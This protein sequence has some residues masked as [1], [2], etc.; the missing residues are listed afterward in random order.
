MPKIS[1]GI[2]KR[3]YLVEDLLLL[4]GI[5][6][7]GKFLLA[8]ILSSFK[9]IEPVQ[10]YG[11]LEHIPFFER[12]GLMDRETSKE[13]LHCE[14]DFHCY[15]TL[16]GRNLN[17]R[18]SDKSS[19]YNNPYRN[20]Y[21]KRAEEK[22]IDLLL[23]NFHE[24]KPYSFFITH[25]L[26]PHI[27][28]YL[29]TFPKIKIIV[30]ERNAIDLVHS[31]WRRGIGTRIG[32]DPIMFQIP[33]RKNSGPAVPWYALSRDTEYYS[34][35]E[36]D[37]IVFA[38]K[39]LKKTYHKTYK[40]LSKG[41]QKKFLFIDYDELLLRPNKITNELSKFLDIKIDQKEI[42]NIMINEDLPNS[43]AIQERGKKREELKKITSEKYFLE[44]LKLE[45]K[46]SSISKFYRS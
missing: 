36:V 46:I 10:Y 12:F 32:S 15:E 16:I 44:L 8:N 25:E 39:T 33:L 3:K 29:E 23:K 2:G 43:R 4:D 45:R 41:N 24:K 9:N 18:R 11:L 31:W 34:L 38:I 22:N 30:I 13:L 20:S 7:S 19:I 14:I 1:I 6:R 35:S 37:R 42:N 28:I 5:T 21:K 17:H 27:D 26:L 40:G